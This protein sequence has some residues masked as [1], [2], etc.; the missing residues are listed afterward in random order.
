MMLSS[1]AKAEVNSGDYDNVGWV[2]TNQDY[3]PCVA[4]CEAKT[5]I[6]WWTPQGEI[7]IIS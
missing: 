1:Q 5:S 6:H 2:T 3:F 7:D 4:K